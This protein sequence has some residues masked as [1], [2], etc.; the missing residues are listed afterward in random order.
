MD[1]TFK[2]IFDI[3]LPALAGV[4]GVW[5]QSKQAARRAAKWEQHVDDTLAVQGKRLDNGAT[6][7]KEIPIISTKLDLI[8]T[9]LREVRANMVTRTECDRTH[10][11]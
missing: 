7:I 11:R 9:D 1:G 4:G 8:A 2:E 5:W 6:E 3:A 10:K